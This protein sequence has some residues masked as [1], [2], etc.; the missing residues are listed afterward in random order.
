MDGPL[1]AAML[2]DDC[3]A[4]APLLLPRRTVRRGHSPPTVAPRRTPRLFLPPRYVAQIPKI[5]APNILV[6]PADTTLRPF[7]ASRQPGAVCF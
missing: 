4:G 5:H 1:F 2:S 6:T 7:G 3:G